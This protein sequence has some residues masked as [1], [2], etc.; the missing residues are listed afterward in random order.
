MGNAHNRPVNWT[1]VGGSVLV[2]VVG[3]LLSWLS[4]RNA[5]N[6]GI[7]GM[8]GVHVQQNIGLTILQITSTALTGGSMVYSYNAYRGQTR[9]EAI[10]NT[11]F[12]TQEQ[13]IAAWNATVLRQLN[14]YHDEVI[15]QKEQRFQEQKACMEKLFA[16]K[17]QQLE[18]TKLLLEQRLHE[19]NSSLVGLQH[20]LDKQGANFV[21]V[22][23]ALI[24]FVVILLIFSLCQNVRHNRERNKLMVSNH[25]QQE[26]SLEDRIQ[27]QQQ[28]MD[29]Q[30]ESLT[31]VIDQ[32]RYQQLL[33]AHP[34]QSHNQPLVFTLPASMQTTS[35]RKNNAREFPTP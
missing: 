26:R 11:A 17:Q 1:Q 6:N 34:M 18:E 15:H 35:E 19:T 7:P 27:L 4:N 33:P 22:V 14:V 10:M 24:V 9:F 23:I 5:N 25:L 21:V 2:N 31:R 12:E 32:Q 29:Q 8:T 3:G 16:A 30:K 28:Q 13:H 20:R